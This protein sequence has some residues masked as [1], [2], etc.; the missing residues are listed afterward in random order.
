MA[1]EMPSLRDLSQALAKRLRAGDENALQDLLDQFGPYVQRR[2]E[3]RFGALLL[4]EDMEDVMS[5]ALYRA[6]HYREKYEPARAS[7]A[8]WFYVIARNIALELTSRRAAHPEVPLRDAASPSVR[9]TGASGTHDP[10]AELTA[11]RTNLAELPPLDQKILLGWAESP[12]EG[13]W[14]AELA[15]ELHLPPGTIRSRK[16]RALAKLREICRK[17]T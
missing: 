8:T 13:N 9:Q 11:L 2:L 10:S 3:R 7:L 15:A 6:W 12:D 17:R 16:H 5:G 1:E 14:A 4:P